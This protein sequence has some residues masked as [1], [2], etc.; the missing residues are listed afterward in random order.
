MQSTLMKI[1]DKGTKRRTPYDS[2]WNKPMNLLLVNY[3]LN[4]IKHEWVVP[5]TEPCRK[6]EL[7]MTAAYICVTYGYS[8]RGCKGFWVD[9]QRLIYGIHIGKYDRQE[10]HVIVSV[11]GIYKEG[12]GDLMHLLLLITV[13]QSAIMIRIWLEILVALLKAEGRN[14]CPAFCDKE[15]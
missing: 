15:G 7:F 12:D 14:I 13:T 5:D 6:R 3:I 9:F 1:F 10:T 8:L 4:H 2:D 11:M